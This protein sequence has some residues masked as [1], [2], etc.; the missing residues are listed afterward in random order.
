MIYIQINKSNFPPSSLA[1]LVKLKNTRSLT[2]LSQIWTPLSLHLLP[3][4]RFI[5]T[6]NG[7]DL[8]YNC[9]CTVLLQS[10]GA[11]GDFSCAHWV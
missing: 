1:L 11:E 9:R 7:T 6:H 4:I 10:I 3:F 5:F 8:F 2:F